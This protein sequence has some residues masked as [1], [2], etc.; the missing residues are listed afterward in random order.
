MTR[1]VDLIDLAENIA[2]AHIA[3]DGLESMKS[4][5]LANRSAE[6]ALALCLAAEEVGKKYKAGACADA[7]VAESPGPVP[8]PSVDVRTP[9]M[10]E[11][12]IEIL[13]F[14]PWF[15]FFVERNGP[16]TQ[17]RMCTIRNGKRWEINQDISAGLDV[18]PMALH[19]LSVHLKEHLSSRDAS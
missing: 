16:F 17:I 13:K 19:M 1:I 6:L 4:N 15:Q 3:R 18:E 11:L 10:T 5:A 9:A 14:D 7:D 2:I 12:V 8:S